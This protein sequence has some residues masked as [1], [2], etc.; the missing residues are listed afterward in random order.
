MREA[1]SKVSKKLED[2]MKIGKDD[3]KAERF[4]SRFNAIRKETRKEKAK[5]KR[6]INKSQLKS[7]TPVL[8]DVKMR[9]INNKNKDSEEEINNKPKNSINNDLLSFLKWLDPIAVRETIRSNW[10]EAKTEIV[11]KIEEDNQTLEYIDLPDRWVMAFDPTWTSY[12][13]ISKNPVFGLG[14]GLSIIANTIF[15]NLKEKSFTAKQNYSKSKAPTQNNSIIANKQTENITNP[16]LEKDKKITRN[17]NQTSKRTL[18]KQKFKKF[19]WKDALVH[20]QNYYKNG[21]AVLNDNNKLKKL[22]VF[23]TWLK[24]RTKWIPYYEIIYKNRKISFSE[25]YRENHDK[26]LILGYRN[27]LNALKSIKIIKKSPI[28]AAETTDSQN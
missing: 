5:N 28:K 17:N 7:K 13:N 15:W 24:N 6:N 16:T 3:S 8:E 27:I 10:M 12:E 21:V 25:F 4:E 22:T 14:F 1:R 26:G 9:E 20:N 19:E 18:N 11:G 23:W 2:F